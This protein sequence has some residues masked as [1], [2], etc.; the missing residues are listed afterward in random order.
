MLGLESSRRQMKLQPLRL[1][2]YFAALLAA[3]E[4]HTVKK[5]SIGLRHRVFAVVVD[6]ELLFVQQVVAFG[7]IP[8]E[9]V[10]LAGAAFAF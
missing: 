10:D 4:L 6:D 1:W 9:L 2:H 3:S 8:V 5:I 7:A